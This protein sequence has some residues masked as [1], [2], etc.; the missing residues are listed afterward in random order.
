[1][2]CR[3]LIH[4][5]LLLA[6]SRW[7]DYFWLGKGADHLVLLN[8]VREVEIAVVRTVLEETVGEHLFSCWPL[9]WANLKHEFHQTH[10]LLINDGC[11][12]ALR[13]TCNVV[14]E[15]ARSSACKGREAAIWINLVEQAAEAGPLIFCRHALI[16]GQ[17]DL[18]DAVQLVKL[19]CA[20]KE[21]PLGEQ[22]CEDTSS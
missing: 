2:L 18:E 6:T 3:L 12:L 19:R 8:Q 5:L 9:F 14:A 11:L 13:K 1:M 7:S 21:R 20:L 16:A 10:Q 15:A 22:L 17:Q 4:S